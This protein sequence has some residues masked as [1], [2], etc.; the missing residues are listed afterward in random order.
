M[1]TFYSGTVI[2]DRYKIIMVLQREPLKTV[3]KAADIRFPG[4]F[5]TVTQIDLF[6]SDLSSIDAYQVAVHNVFRELLSINHPKI[7]KVVDYFFEGPSLFVVTEHVE[8]LNLQALL[9]TSSEPLPEKRVLYI[10]LQLLDIVK[11]LW[12]K[13]IIF[14]V[15]FKPSAFIMKKTGEIIL[16]EFAIDKFLTSYEDEGNFIA[17][18]IGYIPPEFLQPEKGINESSYIY[19]IGAIMYELI[20]K[21]PPQDTP[22]SFLPVTSVNPRASIYIEKVIQKATSYNPKERYKSFKEFQND[23]EFCI[24]KLIENLELPSESFV[25]R[26][27]IGKILFW[28]VAILGFIILTALV[29]IY[30]L[31]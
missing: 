13:R 16:S 27:S 19:V 28:S 1:T 31:T 17:G 5:W 24:K 6:I 22:F 14:L 3:Y 8:G 20:T 30:I 21:L 4:K 12:S 10:G 11:Y 29:L 15:D 23:L 25:E 18:T 26:W 7:A 2:K 9:N